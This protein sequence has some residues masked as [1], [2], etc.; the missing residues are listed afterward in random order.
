MSTTNSEKENYEVGVFQM[1]S[2][3]D[4]RQEFKEGV[5]V[6]VH[7]L[8]AEKKRLSIEDS[9]TD[10]I[11]RAKVVQ[12]IKN[13]NKT[14]DMGD[15][16]PLADRASEYLYKMLQQVPLEEALEI[17]KQAL[18]DHYGD[19]N[20]ENETYDK[21]QKLADGPESF[22]GD[23]DTYD[24][25]C[26]LEATVIKY[27]SPYPE[28]RAVTDPFDDV[29]MPVETIRAY[30][31]G[32]IWVG[33]GSFINEFFAFR[34]PSLTLKSTVI[35]LFLYPCGKATQLL[36]DWGFSF[37]GVRYSINPGPWTIKEQMLAVIMV[38]AGAQTSNWMSMSVTLRHELFFGYSWATTGFAWV[39]NFA[40]LFFGYGLAGMMRKL[41][42]FPVKAVF[43]SVL[44][45]L[46]LSRALIVRERKFSVNGWTIS[47]Q[48][49]FYLTFVISFFYFF[50]PTFLFKALSDFN[51]MTW[52]APQNKKVALV[53]GTFV[54]AGWNPFPSFDW[55]VINYNAPLVY[56]CFAYMNFYVGV[57]IS[58]IFTTALYF[59]N[60]RY[61]GYFPLN[62]NSVYDRTGAEYNVTRILTD[63]VFD[64]EKYSAY[65][66][67]FIASGNLVGTG[68]LW[69]VYTCTFVYICISEWRLLWET[70]KM[71]A[72]SVRHPLR[73]SLD[74]FEDP[75]SRMMR[76]YPEVPDYWFLIV[77]VIG[78]GTAFAG[79]FAW[80]TH[81]PIWTL[82]MIFLFN[83]AMFMPTLVVMSRT[84]FS[85][86]FG[87]FSVILAGYMDPGNAVTSILLR[88]WG[89]N[90]DNQGETFIGDQKIAHYA[91]IPQ[92]AT[93]RAQMVATLIQC[94]CT[95]GAVEALFDSVVNF[96]STTQKDKFTCVFSR[97][98]YSD[99][100]LYGVIDPD[101]VLGTIY[102]QLKYS[103]WIGAL[104]A[105][106]FGFLQ[107]YFPQ[108]L[109]W[110]S[111]ALIGYGTIEIGYTYN[112][113]YY[114][115]GVYMS[116]IFMWYLRTRYVAWWTKYNYIL[117][118]G[119]SAGVAFSAII[120]FAALQYPQVTLSWW[121]N[122]VYEAGLDYAG[123]TLLDVPEGG[124]GPAIGEF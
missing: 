73:N 103:F 11:E 104:F 124:I 78:I 93:F 109:K 91:K 6:L 55:S 108:K 16:D 96:C 41:C 23:F 102:P 43:P 42:I 65:S 60:Y 112:L 53:T 72:K 56:P 61:T 20:F 28:V 22:D 113:T 68:G 36:P 97:T 34:Q 88:M 50:V 17:I 48:K 47:R 14:G 98:V 110:F 99:A 94:C 27:H 7:Q 87:A 77:F 74:D 39:M 49:F 30:V 32:A 4:T 40:S 45:T 46:A 123:T 13:M 15:D 90:I 54:G 71:M 81:C 58:V 82:I 12:L 1:N 33:V 119:L 57:V 70:L 118:S 86:G 9:E 120:I 35:Q 63:N 37:R 64:A 114:T 106:P 80:P 24:L 52:I 8:D 75:H 121:G 105:V 62:S 84:G 76:V 69:A 44:P 115:G 2:E 95:V 29:D 5:E 101:R 107:L 122:T 26:R 66:P 10:E 31:L 19:V 83:I 85:M 67:P 3:E 59:A 51:W 116:L 117:T 89:Y 21:L 92:R 38:N 25:E 100:I 111:I 18:V 79:I